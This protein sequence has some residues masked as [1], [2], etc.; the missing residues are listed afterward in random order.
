MGMFFTYMIDFVN[1]IIKRFLSKAMV[2][3][4]FFV[5]G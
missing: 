4:I 2:F 1:Y 3:S 5:L